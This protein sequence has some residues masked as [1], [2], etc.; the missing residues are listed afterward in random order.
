MIVLVWLMDDDWVRQSIVDGISAMDLEVQ[1]V[2]LMCDR[3]EL[4]RR[5]KN[6]DMCEW[7]TDEWLAVSLKSLPQFTSQKGIIDTTGLSIREVA[8]TIMG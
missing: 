3:D 6:D 7:R 4:V 2:T 5:W 1:Y 8:E